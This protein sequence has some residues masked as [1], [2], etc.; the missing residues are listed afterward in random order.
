MWITPVCGPTFETVDLQ[1][2]LRPF[3]CVSNQDPD[4]K[5]ALIQRRGFGERIINLEFDAC[6]SSSE[7]PTVK[8]LLVV[9]QAYSDRYLL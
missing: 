6:S 8:V 1:A 2:S 7:Y 5:P 3:Y 4:Q 9:L